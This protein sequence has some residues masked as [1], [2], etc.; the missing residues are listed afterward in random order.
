LISGERKEEREEKGRAYHRIER[1]NGSFP[2]RVTLPCEVES[3][4]V[5]AQCKN[6]VLTVILP[7]SELNQSHKITV[8]PKF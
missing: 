5:Q 7:K 1:M 3:S 2:R 8:K 4:E 6:G